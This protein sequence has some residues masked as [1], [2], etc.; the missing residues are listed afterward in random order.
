MDNQCNV[1]KD[2]LKIESLKDSP[3]AHPLLLVKDDSEKAAKK[4]KLTGPL[5][6][7][8]IESSSVLSRIKNFL[9]YSKTEEIPDPESIEGDE[10]SERQIELNLLLF[11]QSSDEGKPA[12]KLL[13]I[14]ESDSDSSSSGTESSDGGSEDDGPESG[15][16]EEA[17]D[18]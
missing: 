6:T 5:I 8:K 4:P 1:S 7:E 3:K 14:L 9:D 12:A 17:E 16:E 2:L 11:K 18:Q 10:D 13:N 15:A